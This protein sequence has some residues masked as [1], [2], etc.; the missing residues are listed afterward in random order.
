MFRPSLAGSNIIVVQVMLPSCEYIVLMLS[1]LPISDICGH[2]F[3]PY[4]I[5]PLPKM[6][7][8]VAFLG[9]QHRILIMIF[10]SVSL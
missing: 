3:S 8:A 7:G 6:Q 1:V 4:V 10:T 9:Q 2:Y 5:L